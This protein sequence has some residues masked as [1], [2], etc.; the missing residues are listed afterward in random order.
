MEF[1]VFDIETDNLLDKVT[2]IHCLSYQ[3]FENNKFIS[4]GSITNYNDIRNFFKVR[5][6]LVGHN[7]IKYDIPVVEKILGIEV[8]TKLIDTLALSY[9]LYPYKKKPGLESW[10]EELGFPKPKITDWTSLTIEE[11]IF[12]CESDVEINSRLF[13]RCIDY[14]ID[15]Y[16]GLNA[17]L[18]FI[19]YIGFKM[20]CIR[21]Q[22]D[23]GIPLDEP[24]VHKHLGDLE[25][26]L[27]EKTNFLISRMPLDLGKVLKQRPKIMFKQDGQL[28]SHGIKWIQYLKDNNLP[29]TTEIVR[30]EPNPGS[31]VQLKN[32]LF[33]LGWEP[34]TF[35]I[36][37]STKKEI[38]QISLPFGAGLCN[39]VKELYEKEPL[40]QELEG[41]F[42]MKHRIGVFKS[43]LKNK[44]ENGKVY[45]TAHGLTNTLR[46]THSEPVVNLPK[47][48]VFYG[49]EI[50]EVL[51]IPD[52]SYVMIGSD[53]SGLEDNTKQHYIYFHDPEYVNEM[54]VPGFDAHVDIGK[55]AGLIS[56]EEEI[57]FRRIEALSD[58]EKKSINE[59]DKKSYKSIKERRGVAKTANFACTYGAGGPKVAATAKI[60]EK[61]GYKLHKIY[62]ERN[63]AV[64]KIASDCFVKEVNYL[65][66]VKVH[67]PT[68]E[69]DAKGEP[70]TIV[71]YKDVTKTQKW[72]YNPLSGYWLFL[73]AE[74]DRFS[75][76]NQ[77]TGVFVFDSWV[78]QVRKRLKEFNI[79]LCLQYH[80]ELLLYC[81]KEHVLI[82]KQILRE[83]MQIVNTNLKLNIE[84]KIS[85]DEGNNYA[86]CH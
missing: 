43:Y 27:L 33:R 6:N 10:G 67:T 45:A 78:Y 59:E 15:I 75:T 60:T 72:L 53:V 65:A 32:W 14:M 58:E 49:K 26:K 17:S 44:D 3:I 71:E 20:D 28:S 11:Y 42:K 29:E 66:T 22:E 18:N 77:N 68:G 13:I 81:K 37:K 47:P 31:D 52:E 2:K 25:P 9:Y 23:I 35:K 50:R 39:S 46:L 76:L 51:T 56:E 62:W 86:E 48:G 85:V 4:K 79:K 57:L 80:D 19:Q 12:R 30:E 82:V 40:L 64:K 5:Q 1:C 7:I 21:E 74:K 54:R 61:E 84:I 63:W 73:K 16:G 8:T 34:V 38:P 24:L 83:S 69:V 55:L 36:S 70:I 41:Y